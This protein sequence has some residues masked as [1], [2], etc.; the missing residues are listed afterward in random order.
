VAMDS[1]R[2]AQYWIVKG[3]GHNPDSDALRELDANVKT[4][5][6]KN[7]KRKR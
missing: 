4:L 2:Q 7:K 1:L 6:V 3:I 5:L